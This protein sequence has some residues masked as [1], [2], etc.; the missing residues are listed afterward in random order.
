MPGGTA[1]SKKENRQKSALSSPGKGKPRNSQIITTLPQPNT[2]ENLQPHLYSEQQREPQHLSSE[3]ARRPQHLC[4]VAS[5]AEKGDKPS[6]LPAGKGPPLPLLQRWCRPGSSEA[7]LMSQ[8]A[9][10]QRRPSGEEPDLQPTA[11][12][13][14]VTCP[15]PP[16]EQCHG[17][18]GER[19]FK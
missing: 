5:E 14:G 18:V 19:E 8:W 13:D 16:P 3:G 15:L 1:K 11:V 6:T 4:K 7:P 10:F 2:A 9:W 17:K 12:S